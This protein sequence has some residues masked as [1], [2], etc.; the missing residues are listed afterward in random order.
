MVNILLTSLIFL[1]LIPI[2]SDAITADELRE[3]SEIGRTK[4]RERDGRIKTQ[5]LK[6]LIPEE[7]KVIPLE[8]KEAMIQETIKDKTMSAESN[9]ANEDKNKSTKAK[10]YNAGIE[11]PALRP[12]GQGFRP[13]NEAQAATFPRGLSP[14]MFNQGKDGIYLPPPRIGGY[15]PLTDAPTPDN[16][17]VF[18]I[19][20]G[21][22]IEGK[23]RRNASNAEPG[24]IEIYTTRDIRGD[25]KVLPIGTTLFAQKTYNPGTKKLD[26]LVEK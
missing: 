10:K 25:K 15:G 19:R 2:P 4:R 1:I 3:L 24:L 5:D 14:G 22:W 17:R 23:L 20:I 9:Q 13:D 8:P 7:A 11:P 26:L 16:I 6:M 21:T 18:G 12:E